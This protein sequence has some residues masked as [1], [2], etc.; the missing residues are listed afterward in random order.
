MITKDTDIH[1]IYWPHC[2]NI[3]G[4]QNMRLHLV[5]YDVSVYIVQC[6]SNKNVLF[7]LS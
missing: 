3:M 6:S 2:G 5:I 4:H 7:Y 1:E